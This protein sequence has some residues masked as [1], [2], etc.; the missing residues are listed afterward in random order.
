MEDE[1]RLDW[2]VVLEG[3]IVGAY[4]ERTVAYAVA[5]DL[6]ATVYWCDVVKDCFAHM[7]M[8][9]DFSEAHQEA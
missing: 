3:R 1:L 2:I 7:A 9:E 6:Q 5:K 8:M 4:N